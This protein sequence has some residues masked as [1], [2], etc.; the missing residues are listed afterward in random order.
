MKWLAVLCAALGL[1][2][3]VWGGRL[4][5]NMNL[6]LAQSAATG[7]SG[8]INE[9]AQTSDEVFQV[10]RFSRAPSEAEVKSTKLT[11]TGQLNLRYENYQKCLNTSTEYCQDFFDEGTDREYYEDVL[12]RIHSDINQEYQSMLKDQA[13]LSPERESFAQ[14]LLTDAHSEIQ[15]LGLKMLSLFPQS[16]KSL[17]DVTSMLTLTID[18]KVLEYGLQLLGHYQN[19]PGF[20]VKVIPMIGSQISFGTKDTAKVATNSVLQF[21]NPDS[22][23]HFDDQRKKMAELAA[24]SKKNGGHDS[25]ILL[26]LRDLDSALAEYERLHWV[27]H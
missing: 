6:K 20:Q 23:L 24:N 15:F 22:Y 3:L 1:S 19:V 9:G 27:A 13:L 26:R 21:L 17:N 12:M 5:K 14:M 4:N 11:P 10:G 18:P 16:E 7:M 8:L 2:L 25:A